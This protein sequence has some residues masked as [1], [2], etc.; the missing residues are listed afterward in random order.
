MATPEQQVMDA[1]GLNSVSQQQEEDVRNLGVPIGTGSPALDQSD[2]ASLEAFIASQQEQKQVDAPLEVSDPDALAAFQ[3]SKIQNKEDEF[4][5]KLSDDL[6]GFTLGEIS[7]S[8]GIIASYIN[9][10]L[11]GNLLDLPGGLL[12]I[13]T[14]ADPSDL[15]YVQPFSQNFL[16]LD[17]GR[18]FDPSRQP[19]SDELKESLRPLGVGLEFAAGV[20]GPQALINKYAQIA[21]PAI[22]STPFVKGGQQALAPTNLVRQPLPTG[23]QSVGG[24]I[25][26]QQTGRAGNLMAGGVGVL[27][28]VGA[29]GASNLSDG[30]PLAE[31][32][33]A[34]GLPIAALIG[35]RSGAGLYSLAKT[36]KDLV[37]KKAVTESA[38]DQMA[39]HATD[40]KKSI[41]T[42]KK[43]L[44]EG[45]TGDLGVLSEDP[46]LMSFVKLMRSKGSP[47][48]TQAKFSTQAVEL[49]EKSSR[50][51]LTDLQ[52]VTDETADA[53]FSDFIK[54]RE[55]GLAKAIQG[56][57][58]NARLEA[59]SAMERAGTALALSVDEAAQIASKQADEAAEAATTGLNKLWDAVPDP[60]VNR[61]NVEKAAKSFLNRAAL[62]TDQEVVAAGK[63]LDPYFKAL[64]NTA[65]KGRVPAREIIKFRSNMLQVT[66]NLKAK[67]ESNA[68]LQKLA[69]DAQ[70]QILG[71]L[72]N[73]KA[74]V[75]YRRAA[76]ETK[77][78]HDI[79]KR[80]DI[81]FTDTQT[82]GKRMLGVGEG[83]AERVDQ[84]AK[85]AG[86]NE[87][88]IGAADDYVRA[89][90]ANAA[91]K[92]GVV[93]PKS[94]EAFLK[95]H[96][97]YLAQPQNR[98]L[99]AELE[100]AA[101]TQK[102]T[103]ALI[104][105]QS[106]FTSERAAAAFN[107]FSLLDDP[108]RAVQSVLRN[109]QPRKAM[110]LLVRQAAKDP[111]GDAL[112]GLR[113]TFVKTLIQKASGQKVGVS[114]IL[115]G[116]VGKLK[117]A[118]A[119]DDMKPVLND[120]FGDSPE[121]LKV[122]DD[123][124]SQIKNIQR[125][126]SAPAAADSVVERVAFDSML[127]YIGIRAAPIVSKG[128]GAGALS[129]AGKAS[130]IMK[131]LFSERPKQQA[132]QIIEEL[133]VNPEK[134]AKVAAAVANARDEVEMVR[135][136]TGFLDS[137]TNP[138][139]YSEEE[140]PVLRFTP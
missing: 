18:L 4:T 100:D 83:G 57:A 90:F 13:A 78:V 44:A 68:A 120:L 103:D 8:A 48:K 11:V 65:Q 73:S 2:P 66:R 1:L 86:Y 107:T 72:E 108:V 140:E 117:G 62:D 125:A 7:D 95:K 28:G 55:Q 102:A 59:K 36:S 26:Q 3:M 40:F 128:S 109:K 32:A 133:M 132:Y 97:S 63:T 82:I 80:G 47:S 115:E 134:Y 74:S 119:Y 123:V 136:A 77:K 5:T 101:F 9:K 118:T 98:Q 138:A 19:G 20:I 30:S 64:L 6:D 87:G 23:F 53:F 38:I 60:F 129:I 94:A 139:L 39:T 137:F 35:V 88:L 96:Q 24:S 99:R 126:S 43:N 124:F 116:P 16:G 67:N 105:K 70:E 29:F 17:T 92:D 121:Q 25:A 81:D 112:E 76:N 45:K 54:W 22:R 79:F 51:L 14:G 93:V 61:A 58:D 10:G 131:K 33:G 52:G 122:I 135:A 127:Q 85:A 113:R 46:G 89:A 50:Q 130:S 104:A 21:A 69:D 31:A 15:R 27:S 49:D 41:L 12:N 71:V 106:Q 114:E 37:G 42:V 110:N 34:I 56:Q 111:T 75:A 91:I 84:I